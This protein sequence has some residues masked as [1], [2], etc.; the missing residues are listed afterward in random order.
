[1]LKESKVG[2]EK[3]FIHPAFVQLLTSET[4]PIEPYMP[5]V[6]VADDDE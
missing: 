2:R 3:L 4:H 6:A 1:M 5:A